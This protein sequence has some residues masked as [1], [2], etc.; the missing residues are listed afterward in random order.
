MDAETGQPTEIDGLSGTEFNVSS[1]GAHVTVSE[2][3]EFVSEGDPGHEFENVQD[4]LCG[5]GRTYSSPTPTPGQIDSHLDCS[6]F[7]QDFA[8]R[9]AAHPEKVMQSFLPEQL[10]V[11]TAL[12]QEFAVCDHWFSSM[13][14]PTW[15]NRFFVHAATAGGLDHSPTVPRELGAVT[16]VDGYWFTN[17]TIFDRLDAKGLEWAVYEGD[18]MPQTLAI[19]G[20]ID[21]LGKGRFPDYK[22]FRDDV[23]KQ[24]FSKSYVFIE[25]DWH[26]FNHFK[27]GNSQHPMDD[28]TRGEKLIKD[29]YETVRKS[30][31]WEKSLLII[32]YDEHGGFYDHVPPPTTVNPGDQITDPENN[33]YHFNFQQLGIRVPTVVVSPLIPRGVVDHRVYDHA[34]VL[35]T[36]EGTF[37]INYLTQ[38]DKLAAPLGDLL[39]LRQARTDA[40]ESLPGPAASGIRC[41]FLND[42]ISRASTLLF[43]VLRG[44][45]EVMDPTLRGFMHVALLRNLHHS[46]DKKAELITQFREKETKRDALKYLRRTRRRVRL[47]GR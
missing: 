37:G 39:S 5:M 41:N 11:L 15:P 9:G 36:V 47:V 45:P 8:S 46:P 28:V 34:S 25:P 2:G 19:K 7:L 6:G 44:A 13:P 20:M 35:S 29:V 10:P 16:S 32:T 14:G 43:D 23:N 40:P 4:Q 33:K 3:A 1:N 12:A 21:N 26:A 22:E 27:C 24:D 42:L 18:E 38:R 31:H 17:G 30:P